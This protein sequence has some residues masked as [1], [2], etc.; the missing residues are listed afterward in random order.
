M[1]N[2]YTK[3]TPL[4]NATPQHEQ[5]KNY[6]TKEE[7]LHDLKNSYLKDANR[8]EANK[9]IVRLRLSSGGYENCITANY[10][11]DD[12]TDQF[13]HVSLP[14]QIQTKCK[15]DHIDF[16]DEYEKKAQKIAAEK[17]ATETGCF[18]FIDDW[19]TKKNFFSD[20]TQ[21]YNE[22][23]C[24]IHLAIASDIFR[25]E[26]SSLRLDKIVEEGNYFLPSDARKKVKATLPRQE[27]KHVSPHTV[28]G[29]PIPN[30]SEINFHDSS[31]STEHFG[32]QEGYYRY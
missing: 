31:I 15:K 9:Q 27:N 16:A 30:S 12:F 3:E 8:I 25:C 28:T 10:R 2:Y 29:S 22:A 1:E 20:N 24:I 32:Y 18:S 14:L 11:I 23:M 7:C 5:N 26:D 19:L 4:L 21:E 17:T 6:A 13:K